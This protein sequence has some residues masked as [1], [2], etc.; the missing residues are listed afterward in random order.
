MTSRERFKLVLSHKEPDR[1]P[2]Y[3]SVWPTTIKRWNNEGLPS[4]VTPFE[5]FHYELSEIY[6]DVTFQ[7][8]E[9][10]VKET[11]EYIIVRNRNGALRKD[12]KDK[13]ATPEYIS[14]LVN[15]SDDWL[16]IKN[17]MR[18]NDSRI[19]Y[20]VQKDI[21]DKSKKDGNFLCFAAPMGYDYT[22]GLIGTEKLLINMVENPD[23]T[24][25][26]FNTIAELIIDGAKRFTDLG[27]EYDGAFLFDDNGYRNAT[28]F[29]PSTYKKVLYPAHKKVFSF[30]K[31]MGIPVILHS[32]GCVK[33]F[34][35]FYIEGGV[36]CLQ[37]LEVKAGMDI[38]ELKEKYGEKISFM[39]GIDV[40]KMAADDPG[41]IEE[42]IKSKFSAAKEGGGYIYHSDHSVPDNISFEQYKRVIELVL[43]YGKY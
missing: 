43:K 36:D 23:W 40:R 32:C 38:I 3:D 2:I 25:D 26:I 42:E 13:T 9:E 15:T 19:D 17:R 14:F 30:F 34:I 41:I 1:V 20:K 16:K 10:V 6:I 12:W 37:P 4:G 31:N 11:E 18:M 29:S 35:P 5:F 33:E 28:L 22:Q 24:A 8:K 21:Y 7:F 39:G 27:F